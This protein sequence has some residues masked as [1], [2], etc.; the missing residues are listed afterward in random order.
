MNSARVRLRRAGVTA[1]LAVLALGVAATSASA[2]TWNTND[3]YL[4]SATAGSETSRWYAV[5]SHTQYINQTLCQSHCAGRISC[6][7]MK[8]V[9]LSPDKWLAWRDWS[10]DN[11]A[12]TKSYTGAGNGYYY[13]KVNSTPSGA[14]ADELNLRVRRVT[15]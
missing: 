10:C 5:G 2:V 12:H 3:R 14:V 13:A 15:S 8:D 6:D 9:S 4:R 11:V 1:L 7:F